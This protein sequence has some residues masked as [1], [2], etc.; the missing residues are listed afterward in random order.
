MTQDAPTIWRKNRPQHEGTTAGL[1]E[2]CSG[3]RELSFVQ[4]PGIMHIWYLKKPPELNSLRFFPT[5]CPRNL[6]NLR[7][8]VPLSIG[9]NK[10]K[11]KKKKVSSTVGWGQSCTPR[12]ASWPATLAGRHPLSCS[13]QPAA[14]DTQAAKARLLSH[15][16]THNPHP[17]FTSANMLNCEL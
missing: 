6:C 3:E 1:T 10:K 7:A 14:W 4:I 12:Y 11:K 13:D 17:P 16:V 2:K 8:H 15:K 5:V 9:L